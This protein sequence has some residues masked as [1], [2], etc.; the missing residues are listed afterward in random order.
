ME[1]GCAWCVPGRAAGSGCGP[2][3]GGAVMMP[4]MLAL[5]LAVLVGGQ[6]AAASPPKTTAPTLADIARQEEARRK[7][8]TQPAKVLTNEDLR[9][10]P[11]VAE[12]APSSATPP[13]S[14]TPAAP[15]TGGAAAAA[16]QARAEDPLKDE[17]WWHKRITDARAAL[18][19]TDTLIAAM[20]SRIN[21]LW[22]DFTA[23][24]DPAQRAQIARDRERA[25]AELARLKEERQDQAKAIADIEEEARQGGVPPGWLR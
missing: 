6:G 23:R 8:I 19:R 15:E 5:A 4:D 3:A 11:T 20:E 1:T 25:L 9:P 18:E 24:D 7:A 2:A 13:S 21:Q 16:T 22:A 12:P 10:L 17:A 14:V